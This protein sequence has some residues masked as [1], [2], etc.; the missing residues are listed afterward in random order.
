MKILQTEWYLAVNK[1]SFSYKD[2][3]IYFRL[4]DKFGHDQIQ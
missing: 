4:Y 1:I 2:R 3:Y